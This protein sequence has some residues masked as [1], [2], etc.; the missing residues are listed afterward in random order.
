MKRNGLQRGFLV[1]VPAGFCSAGSTPRGVF[2][3]TA[4]AFQGSIQNSDK[5]NKEYTVKLTDNQTIESNAGRLRR[6]QTSSR[7]GRS[8]QRHAVAGD[9][10]D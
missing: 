6:T 9:S 3:P 10:N 1:V 4:D 5:Q 7:R 8:I 2:C